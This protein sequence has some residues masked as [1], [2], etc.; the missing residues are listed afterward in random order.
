MKL[1]STI[2]HIH[3]I[4]KKYAFK[5]DIFQ[6][7]RVIWRYGLDKN[8]C[9]LYQCENVNSDAEH[10]PFQKKIP[11]YNGTCL[12]SCCLKGMREKRKKR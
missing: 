6:N 11:G 2:S 9:L 4:D 8:Q 5:I 7:Q 3:I 12:E 10:P 1:P